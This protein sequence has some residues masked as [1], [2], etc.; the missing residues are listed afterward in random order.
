MPRT[1]PGGKP[2][3]EQAREGKNK[4][5]WE[6]AIEKELNTLEHMGCLSL[7]NRLKTEILLHTKFVIK[8]KPY[9]TESVCKS[10]ARIVVCGNKVVGC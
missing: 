8:K 9:K 7:V 6:S 10:K 4:N 1:F 5:G 2:S 3:L